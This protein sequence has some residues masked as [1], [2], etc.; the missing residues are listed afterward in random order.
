MPTLQLQSGPR[1]G[2]R[3]PVLGERFVLG[4][5]V[6]CDAIINDA[7]AGI[8]PLRADSVSRRHARLTLSAGQWYIEDGNGHGR[9]SRN[10]TYVNDQ[11]VPFPGRVRLRDQDRIRICDVRFV[12][13]LDPDSTFA[14]E[15]SVGHADSRPSLEAQP[16]E[17]LRVLLDVSAALRATLDTAAVLDRTLEHLFRLFPQAE[18]GLVVF[19][20]DPTGPP[21]VRFNRTPRG[22]AADPRFSTSVVRRCMESMEAILGNDLPAQFPDSAS[23]GGLLVRSLM[24]SP[25]WSSEGRPLGAIQ[26][27]TQ[28]NS[29]RFTEEDL[30]LLFGVASQASIALSNA[31]LHRQSMTI[32]RQTR[33][34]EVAQQVQRALLP[35]SLPD[36]PGYRFFAHYQAAQEVGGDY[37]DFV[38]LPGSRMGVLLG[39][40]AGH[41]VAA[42]L[43]MAKF[44]VEARVCLE[45]EAEPAKAV[46]R[47]NAQMM[48]AG[49]PEKF[50]TLALAVLDPTTHMVAVV[51]AGHPSPLLLHASG[52]VEE[53]T[54]PEF[55]GLPIG[56]A[57]GYPYPCRLVKLEPGDRLLVYS[58]GVS[59][60]LG[61]NEQ[62]F[63]TDGIRTAI[64]GAGSCPRATGEHLVRAVQ[65]HA[66]GCDPN[67]DITVV[68]F[69]RTA[70]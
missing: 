57:E 41:G 31:H 42:A 47:L 39:D 23:V 27:D 12:F 1:L 40:V 60:A 29:R 61:G 45:F 19:Q 14:V 28:A 25:L 11:R 38:P 32:Q 13:H 52:A 69:G 18:R 22:D 15:A 24:C 8:Q 2:E 7:L 3:L 17:R 10:G 65:R 70:D 63:G 46:T 50:V 26:L 55:A 34:L 16:A 56:I 9:A 30:H 49:M 68:C 43:V 33:D 44:G 51:N 64:G 67:D 35:H 66:A 37:Y 59:D 21:V 6:G 53:V 20:E 58:D 62:F 5:A 36:V 4:R 54:P 48:R